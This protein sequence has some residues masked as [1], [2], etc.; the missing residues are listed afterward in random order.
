VDTTIFQRDPAAP[1]V[2]RVVNAIG[3]LAALEHRNPPQVQSALGLIR[4]LETLKERETQWRSLLAGI[5]GL[6]LALVYGAV[7]ILEFRQNLF[8]SGLLR[9]F[10]APRH[11]L[12]WRHLLE[13]ILLA[14][15][16]ALAAI[17][18]LALLHEAIFGTLG[19]P[20]AVLNFNQGNP[21]TSSAVISILVWVNIGAILSTVPIVIGLRQ[22]VGTI[23]N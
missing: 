17:L 23:L 9:S 20:R 5:L 7:A 13:N 6:A 4:E 11:F 19:F 18:V 12:Y 3:A 1:S 14:N 10:G 8:V 21:Y 16:A 22:P 2:E 15:L